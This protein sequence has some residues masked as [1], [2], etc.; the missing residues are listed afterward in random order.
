MR[1]SIDTLLKKGVSE[2][3]QVALTFGL[4]PRFESEILLG[5]VL[6]VPRVYL[7]THNAHY[8]ESNVAQE[9][10]QCI[11]MR[12]SGMP[13]EYITQSAHF[14]GRRFYVNRS[15]LVPRPESEILIDKADA[16]IK[17]HHIRSIVEIGIGSGI[18][19][20][21]LALMHP[22]CRF[23]ATDISED[24]I[25]VA[26]KN[27]AH[28]SPDADITLSCCSILPQNPP[29]FGLLISNPP[30]IKDNYA[31]SKPLTFEPKIALFGGQ[32]GLDMYRQIIDVCLAHSPVWLLCEMGYDQKDDMNTLLTSNKAINITF[33]KDL[34]G[35][36]RGFI[37]YFP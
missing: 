32:D 22:Q 16:L 13:V 12:K 30:Y 1:Y 20:I 37:A 29:T 8:I 2:L 17:A 36:D 21:T 6:N 26:A 4:K 28:L 33:Y 24:A 34:S 18:L 5:F 31:I 3:S 19:S 7:H 35:L 27:I 10:L 11:A 14:Y 25:N 9:Y 15:V 23:F